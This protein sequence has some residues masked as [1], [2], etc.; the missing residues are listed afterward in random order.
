MMAHGGS[1]TFDQMIYL[2]VKKLASRYGWKRVA[3]DFRTRFNSEGLR[4][5]V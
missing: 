3:E 5:E 2:V 4:V 1:W